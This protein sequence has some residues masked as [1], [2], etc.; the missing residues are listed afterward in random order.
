MQIV[1]DQISLA[2]VAK[3][4]IGFKCMNVPYIKIIDTRVDETYTGGH[5]RYANAIDLLRLSNDQCLTATA[6]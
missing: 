3:S 2:D 6:R 4:H 1:N 5:I